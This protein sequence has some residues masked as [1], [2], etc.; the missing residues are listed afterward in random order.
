MWLREPLP[1]QSTQRNLLLWVTVH[2][3]TNAHSHSHTVTQSHTSFGY[4]LLFCLSLSL[5]STPLF[6]LPLFHSGQMVHFCT[7]APGVLV[8]WQNNSM[9]KCQVHQKDRVTEVIRKAKKW[10]KKKKI[11]HL[12]SRSLPSLHLLVYSFRKLT[13]S[14]VWLGKI[15]TGSDSKL[16]VQN[17][18]L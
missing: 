1:W 3:A 9:W 8:L 13:K 14:G 4:S 15:V 17:C 7:L 11:P 5:S 2:R 12:S 16:F 6:P 18:C 10:K